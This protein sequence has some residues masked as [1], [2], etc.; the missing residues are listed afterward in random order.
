MIQP[1]GLGVVRPRMVAGFAGLAL[2]A[3]GSIAL[4]QPE[5]PTTVIAPSS[6]PSVT[7]STLHV[8]PPPSWVVPME[9][10]AVAPTADAGAIQVLLQDVQCNI[11]ADGTDC[12]SHLA[13]KALSAT[14]LPAIG[15][16]QPSWNPETNSM[17]IHKLRILRGSEVIDVLN[18][19]KDLTILRR[20][21][22][23]ERAALDGRLTATQQINGVQVGDVLEIET[24]GHH[25]DPALKGVAQ[26]TFGLS[27]PGITSHMRM[28]V[29]WPDS[30]PI[31][32]RTTRGLDQPKLV[33]AAGRNE[34]VEDMTDAP[35]PVAP[36]GAPTRYRYLGRLEVSQFAKWADVARVMDPLFQRAEVLSPTSP[37][38]AEIAKIKA[39]SRAPKVQAALALALVQTQ[40]RYQFV[41]LND[42]G[43]VPAAADLTWSRRYGD[44]KG[45]T[46]LL[47]ALLHGLGIEAEPVLVSTVLGDGLNERLPE[48]S[49]FD[50]VLV[51]AHIGDRWYWLDGT[52]PGDPQDLDDLTTP[53]FEWGLPVRSDAS[54]L[55]KIDLPPATVPLYEV[56]SYVDA[57]GG[58]RAPLPTHVE[59]VQRGD[60]GLKLGMT[61]K[62]VPRDVADRAL[63]A[64]VT[65]L[66]PNLEVKT[67]D[68]SYD[69][70]KLVFIVK[71]DGSST[72][73]WRSNPNNGRSLT[74]L[75][76]AAVVPAP[77]AAKRAPGPESDAPYAELYPYY[78]AYHMA[79]VLPQGGQ[80]FNLIGSDKAKAV[81]G[82][83]FS[84][85]VTLQN[86]VVHLDTSSRST[87]REFPAA[88]IDA[89]AAFNRELNNDPVF[90]SAPNRAGS[91]G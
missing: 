21:T 11:G 30:I 76:A 59:I 10:P 44:C 74:Q 24:T 43:Y 13:I 91:A 62:A 32:W 68:W 57:S 51:R 90:V 75:S 5:P 17:T 56:S 1:R 53:P 9:V 63:R 67:I 77:G 72:L 34:L 65:K 86:G 85:K 58:V 42:G 16:F 37:L 31:Q 33:H 54:D 18:G 29:L 4:A 78:N 41:G 73:N 3:T 15:S 27:S 66:M 71:V 45:K 80:G 19:G 23:L 28:R 40:V 12:Y 48:L 22:N 25:Y 38:T 70:A 87:G 49:Y 60:S 69:P 79:L 84:R 55:I 46:T 64:I 8:G 36:G 35:A 6:S 39:A 7:T 88:D 83:T 81:A 14:G 26:A 47:M 2:A 52:R 89:A 82:V 20:E 50:H 61:I